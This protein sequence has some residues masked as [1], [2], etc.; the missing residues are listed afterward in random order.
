MACVNLCGGWDPCTCGS[1]S[2]L[3]HARGLSSMA[4]CPGVPAESAVEAILGVVPAPPDPNAIAALEEIRR[5]VARVKDGLDASYFT[6]RDLGLVLE[7][8][9]RRDAELKTIRA[10]L[11]RWLEASDRYRTVAND[12]ITNEAAE[13]IDAT[14]ALETLA[15]EVCDG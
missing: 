4:E 8:L 11:R 1:E 12:A 13:F 7:I 6:F 3:I 2:R 14:E 9:D 15:R 5:A 10:T